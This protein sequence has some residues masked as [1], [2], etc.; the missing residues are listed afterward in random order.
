MQGHDPNLV[1]E[2]TNTWKDGKVEVGDLSFTISMDLT[3]KAIGL[4][5]EGVCILR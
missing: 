5:F 2:F 4:S 1:M 3:V